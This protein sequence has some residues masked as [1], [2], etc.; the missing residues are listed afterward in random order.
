MPSSFSRGCAEAPCF[1]W[2]LAFH[3]LFRL[4]TLLKCFLQSSVCTAQPGPPAPLSCTSSAINEAG[5][6][7]AVGLMC[8][9]IDKRSKCILTWNKIRCKKI[10]G[11][12]LFNATSSI[13][14]WVL[15]WLYPIVNYICTCKLHCKLKLY[16]LLCL[17]I[18]EVLSYVTLPTVCR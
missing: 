12:L 2:E 6:S 5:T 13:I 16:L 1:I 15:L 11:S 18:T 14:K 17:L 4:L 10:L 9:T 7:S 8:A 3:A